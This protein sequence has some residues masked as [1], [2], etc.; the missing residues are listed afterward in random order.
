MLLDNVCDEDLYIVAERKSQ[1]FQQ[2]TKMREALLCF[3]EQQ[4]AWFVHEPNE[5]LYHLAGSETQEKTR[6]NPHEME[7][8]VCVFRHLPKSVCVCVHIHVC[9]LPC[10][11]IC[12]SVCEYLSPCVC[13]CAYTCVLL[14]A[15][16]HTCVHGLLYVSEC[17]MRAHVCLICLPMCV[18]RSFCICVCTQCV[19]LCGVCAHVCVPLY[20]C[21]CI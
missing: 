9:V 6:I 7:C 16:A 13:V 17:L 19:S 4:E 12:A 2:S 11:P 18:C 10:D 14:W 20:V 5:R 15:C 8:R 3:W 1:L 21:V